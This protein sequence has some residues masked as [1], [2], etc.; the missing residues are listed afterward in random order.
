[1]E[2]VIGMLPVE[3]QVHIYNCVCDSYIKQ[4]QPIT[5]HIVNGWLRHHLR[6]IVNVTLQE[7]TAYHG[8]NLLQQFKQCLQ[9]RGDLSPFDQ[10]HA[11]MRTHLTE[12]IVRGL[13]GS[14]WIITKKDVT[15]GM[16]S[17]LMA[18]VSHDKTAYVVFAHYLHPCL[19]DEEC[20]RDAPFL[21]GLMLFK[22]VV[23][24]QRVW[25]LFGI[26]GGRITNRQ[27]PIQE[28]VEYIH[29]QCGISHSAGS[30]DVLQQ[31]LDIDGTGFIVVVPP[32]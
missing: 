31:H 15:M 2:D 1:M 13:I 30:L 29:A 6:R 26:D 9:Q 23:S 17:E 14:R 16:I 10:R 21:Y 24:Y 12:N 4:L 25:D 3:L 27:H 19:E 32:S 7:D 22:D 20:I 11:L 18:R 5:A 28:E 8:L